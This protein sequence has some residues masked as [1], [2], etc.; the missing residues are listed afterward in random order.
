MF[1]SSPFFI[2]KVLFSYFLL[3]GIR[4]LYFFVRF[5]C[6]QWG[7]PWTSTA[8]IT[9]TMDEHRIL[10]VQNFTNEGALSI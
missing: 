4:G 10:Q 6:I 3:D 5:S 8:L 2:K 7:R 9:K 1:I